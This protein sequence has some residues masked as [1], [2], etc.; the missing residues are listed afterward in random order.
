M[1]AS[2]VLEVDMGKYKSVELPLEK[3]E[4][5]LSTITSILGFESQD[6]HETYRIIRN[7]DA[8]YEMAKKKYKDYIVPSKSMND[9]ILGRV[10]VDKV[11]LVREGGS[12]RVSI[13]FDRRISEETIIEALSRLGYKVEVKRL[14]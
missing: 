14:G 4:K 13:V 3:A 5:L 1:A 2:I 10:I 9:M 6:I 12:R 11:R 7:F 8:F